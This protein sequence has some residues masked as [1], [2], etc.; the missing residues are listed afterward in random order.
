[1]SGNNVKAKPRVLIITARADFGGG[2]EYVYRLISALHGSI[3]FFV[4]CPDDFPYRTRY[5][6]IVGSE[7]ILIIPHRKFELRSLFNLIKFA[8]QN[9]INVIHS[10]GKGAGIYSRPAALLSGTKCVHAFHG[11][12]MGEYGAL[13]KILYLTLE[14]VLALL[15]EKIIATSVSEKETFLSH[16]ITSEDKIVF[17]LNGVAEAP[18][19]TSGM[20]SGRLNVVT[21]TRFDYAKNALL[22]VDVIQA[23]ANLGFA[24]KFHFTFVGDGED[25]EVVQDRLK[26]MP[27]SVEFT[28]FID[29]PGD[30]YSVAFCYIS[31]SRWEGMP[32]AVLEA[33]SY[34]VPVI[35]TNVRGNRDAVISGENGFLFDESAP[36]DAADH[37]CRIAEDELLWKKLSENS[38]K[39]CNEKFSYNNTARLNSDLYHNISDK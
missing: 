38:V 11:L 6:E 30:Y 39:L 31:T 29:D 5:E 19:K 20:K 2:P 3:D 7:R 32:L 25:R 12:H 16:R 9:K 33:M 37:L 13:G 15:T 18:V 23:I 35:A 22:M 26:D 28:G 21:V 10:H 8:K 24:D 27:V 36:A 17:I 1:L 34:G 4:A 14:R